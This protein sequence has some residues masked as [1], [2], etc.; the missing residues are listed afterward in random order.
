MGGQADTPAAL[1]LSVAA[2]NPALLLAQL[3]AG[4]RPDVAIQGEAQF[5]ADVHWLADNLRWDIEAD[6]ARIA[7]PGPARS[8]TRLGAP[9]P[10]M[11]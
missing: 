9:R 10:P 8:T 7:G 4:E 6:L 5:A 3:A 1:H 11:P 2:A